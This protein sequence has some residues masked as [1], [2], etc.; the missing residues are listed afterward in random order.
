MQA[1]SGELMNEDPKIGLRI[2]ACLFYNPKGQGHISLR[3]LCFYYREE[4]TREAL[5]L[6][7]GVNLIF[8]F[9]IELCNLNPTI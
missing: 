1:S 3:I 7:G 6:G 9:L 5:G 4:G 8:C 2:V